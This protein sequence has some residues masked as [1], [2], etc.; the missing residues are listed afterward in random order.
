MKCPDCD[1]EMEIY[2]FEFC[3]PICGLLLKREEE[4]YNEPFHFKKQTHEPVKLFL[5]WINYILA[6]ENFGEFEKH[7][8]S[9]ENYLKENDIQQ[10]TPNDLRN[11]L[12]QLKLSKYSKHT[13]YYYREITGIAPPDIPERFIYTAKVIFQGWVSKWKKGKNLPSYPYLIYKIFNIV[14]PEKDVENRRIFYFIT[15]PRQ[16]TIDK[17]ERDLQEFVG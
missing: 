16:K 15:L 17:I 1:K 5:N 6:R 2:D 4:I 7:T 9:I 8:S 13:S 12:K 3:C 11:V 10:F 14:L